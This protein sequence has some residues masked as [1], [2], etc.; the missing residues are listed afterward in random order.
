M[1]GTLTVA[2]LVFLTVVLYALD[3]RRRPYRRCWWCR[4]NPGRVP[5]STE[6]RFG[7]CRHCHNKPPQPRLGAQLVRPGIKKEK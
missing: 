1:D 2:A 5:G 3:L 4:G 7:F 6:K